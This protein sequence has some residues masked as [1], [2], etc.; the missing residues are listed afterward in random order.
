MCGNVVLTPSTT[1]PPP[2]LVVAVRAVFATQRGTWTHGVVGPT[3]GDLVARRNGSAPLGPTV[4]WSFLTNHA[5]ALVCIAHDPGVRLRDIATSLRITERSAFG[6]VTDLATAGYVVK[7]K[8][9]RRNRYRIQDHLPLPENIGRERTIG[10]MLDLFV[11]TGA[12]TQA[13]PTP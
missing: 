5:R 10:E 3:V 4:E 7:H 8:D 11:E 9:G 12:E 2:A 6:I 1:A 13:R